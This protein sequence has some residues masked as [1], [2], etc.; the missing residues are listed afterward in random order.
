MRWRDTSRENKGPVSHLRVL[1]RGFRWK[2]PFRCDTGMTIQMSLGWVPEDIVPK[3]EIIEKLKKQSH[4]AVSI[5]LVG[6]GLFYPLPLFP[7]KAAAL[8]M[9]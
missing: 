8:S 3:G 1:V 2:E 4:L 5:T 7:G 9:R 6:R